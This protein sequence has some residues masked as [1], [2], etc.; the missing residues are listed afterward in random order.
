MKCL[1]EASTRE[2]KSA[3]IVLRNCF[4]YCL[5]D[6]ISVN[7]VLHSISG[8]LVFFLSP[9]SHL[10][11]LFTSKNPRPYFPLS[12]KAKVT[13][14]ALM[15]FARPSA[16]KGVAAAA[17]TGIEDG[18]E[19]ERERAFPSC[20]RAG[21]P[22][23]L[24]RLGGGSVMQAPARAFFASWPSLKKEGGREGGGAAALLL[25]WK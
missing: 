11:S 23:S 19:K 15:A 21:T 9:R 2:G 6:P 7:Y 5:P 1:E 10:P 18:R 8:L 25:S 17:L 12:A 20:S 16:K 3:R 24:H 14:D 22:S 13:V 4:C